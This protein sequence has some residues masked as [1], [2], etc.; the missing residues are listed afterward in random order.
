[1]PCAVGVRGPAGD[2]T[3][4]LYVLPPSMEFLHSLA[5]ADARELPRMLR[6]GPAAAQVRLT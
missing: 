2:D 1:M 3:T 6:P 5:A 4:S